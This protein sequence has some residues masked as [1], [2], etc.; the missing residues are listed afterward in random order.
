MEFVVKTKRIRQKTKHWREA[1]MVSRMDEK[2]FIRLELLDMNAHF[3][4]DDE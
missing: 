1:A 3:L 4:E 2:K